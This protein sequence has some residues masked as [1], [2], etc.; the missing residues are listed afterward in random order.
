MNG[1][2]Q[3]GA[4]GDQWKIKQSMR[5]ENKA[6]Q[7]GNFYK[8]VEQGESFVSVTDPIVLQ[9]RFCDTYWVDSKSETDCSVLVSPNI[10]W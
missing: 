10:D 3:G 7:N 2:F 8:M 1:T 4:L 6:K 5:W 9:L